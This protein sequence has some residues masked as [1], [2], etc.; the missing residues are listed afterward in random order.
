VTRANQKNVYNFALLHTSDT[1]CMKIFGFCEDKIRL[2]KNDVVSIGKKEWTSMKTARDDDEIMLAGK[3]LDDA[4]YK[5]VKDGNVSGLRKL[6]ET[7]DDVTERGVCGWKGLKALHVAG[8][9]GHVDVAKLLIQNGAGVNAVDKDNWTSLHVTTWYG[10]VDV[11]KLL[12]QKGAEV[13]AVNGDN[14]TSLHMTAP[15]GHV[16]VAKLLIQNGADVK[17]VDKYDRTSLHVTT[18]NGHVDVAKLLIQNGA[19]VNAVDKWKQSVLYCASCI[20]KSV[21][22]ILELFC[23]GAKIDKKA[24]ENDETGLLVQ[25]EE[26]LE[27]L[28][29]GEY[30][31][32]NL[33][34]NEENKFKWNLAF[35]LTLKYKVAA[36]KAYYSIRS[37]I[38]YHGIFMAPGFD[39]GKESIWR[40]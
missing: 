27:K 10:H 32:T 13:N 23:F 37:F 18:L 7:H 31:I 9:Y 11:A 12:I 39:L 4:I 35:C 38:T 3:E 36:F 21:P 6:L 22:L 15:F 24:L 14:A 5:V 1:S 30:R 20:S 33:C 25:I 40:K 28:R 26:R 17:D 2:F 29:K 34:S 19:D 8:K 16:D